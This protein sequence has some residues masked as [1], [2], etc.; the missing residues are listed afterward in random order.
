MP[1]TV[2]VPKGIVTLNYVDFK[3]P[4]CECPHEEDDYYKKLYKSKNCLIYIKC[5]ECKTKL[6]VTC[7]ILG[8][9]KVWIKAEE[10]FK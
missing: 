3:C 2:I 1:Y 4:K 9:V 8:D 5:K 10:K 7:D 6:G